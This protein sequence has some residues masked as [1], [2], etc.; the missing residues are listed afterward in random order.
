MGFSTS[1]FSWVSAPP[2]ITMT[3]IKLAPGS[4][5]F[6]LDSQTSLGA[7]Q[8]PKFW[9][10]MSTQS[11]PQPGAGSMDKIFYFCAQPPVSAARS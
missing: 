8:L 4:Q 3:Q 7:G 9:P 10:S 2:N 1:S 5:I 6:R 11:Q